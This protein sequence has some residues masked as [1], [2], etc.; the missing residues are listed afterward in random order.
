MH[1]E[2]RIRKVKSLIEEYFHNQPFSVYLKE[3]FRNHPEM[4]SRDRRE[5]REWTFNYFRIGLNLAELPF[6]K[7]LAVA[8]FLCNN[9][10]Y[11]LLS[12]LINTH[13]EFEEAEIANPLISK[14][15]SVK[16]KYPFFKIE[17]IFQMHELLSSEIN[18][19]KWFLSFLRKPSVWI[20]IRKLHKDEVINELEKKEIVFSIDDDPFILS[21]I[22]DPALDKT[23]AYQNGYFEIQDKSSQ[24]VKEFLKS[25]PGE[26]WWDACAGAG[27]KSLLL[28]ED[29]RDVKI[30]ATDIRMNILN[31]YNERMKKSGYKNFSTE[32]ADVSWPIL[33]FDKKF[34]GIIAD[35][36]CSGSGTWGRSPEW[37]L[38]NIKVRID[39]HFIPLQRNIVTS[40]LPSLKE[41][42]PLIYITCSVFKKENEEN[43]QYFLEQLPLRLEKSAYLEGYHNNGDTLFVARFI[44]L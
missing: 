13:S 26:Q 11:P 6:E 28:K 17:N 34:D 12:Y 8:C 24:L 30:F 21:F 35:V 32:V 22:S 43:I 37:L 2:N 5:T 38:K 3:H 16:S 27:G 20:R 36:P 40:I 19:D 14:I 39:Q 42:F 18:K 4:G 25:N 10:I 44:K 9:K 23:I 33:N 31:T 1:E 7:K 41:G 15:E 29:D